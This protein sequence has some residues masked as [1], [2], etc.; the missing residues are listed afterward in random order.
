M[1]ARLLLPLAAALALG[2]SSLCAQLVRA[3]LPVQVQGT[4]AAPKLVPASYSAITDSLGFIWDVTQYGGIGRGSNCFSTAFTLSIDGNDFQPQQGMMTADGREYFITGTCDNCAV[5]RRIR[6]DPKDGHCRFIETLRNNSSE[7]LSFTVMIRTQFNSTIQSIVSDTAVSAPAQLGPKDSGVA[8]IRK[9]TPTRPQPTVLW[10]LGSTGGKLRPTLR[11]EGNTR[12]LA[13][14]PVTL[15]PGASISLIHAAAQRNLPGAA[16]APALAKLFAPLKSSKLV[17][18]L[19]P[20]ERKDFA[21]FAPV[22][23]GGEEGETAPVLAALQALLEASEITR[24]K[25]DTV[26]LDA[27]AKVSGT[28]SGGAL[29]IETEFGKADVPFADIAGI[30]GGGGVQ[31][32]VR[33]FLR[34]GEVL[35]GAVSGEKFAMTTDSG[36][37]FEID[38]AQIQ[39]LT[40]RKGGDDGKPPKSA[41]ALLTTQRGDCLALVQKA[42]ADVQMATPWGMLSVPPAEIVQLEY[43]REPFPGH[44][45]TLTDRSRLPVMLRGEEWQLATVRFG[46]VKIAP[47]SV[48]GLRGTAAKPKPPEGGDAPFASCELSGEHRL[49]GVIDLPTLHLASAKNTTPL[50]TMTITTLTR[51]VG[52]DAQGGG[53][54]VKIKLADGQE[55]SGQLVEST[56]PIRS[57]ERVW[58]V[59]AA[60][61]LSVNVPPPA[62]PK[63]ETPPTPTAPAAL[64]TPAK[65]SARTDE[66][67]NAPP[68]APPAPAPK[69]P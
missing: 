9:G 2:V 18:D 43:L 45:L 60:H 69:K 68:D 55:I 32:T 67:I 57:G 16:D 17:A 23:I 39:L 65:P 51:E 5:T 63:D 37:H 58:R 25:N 62:K 28:V 30:A 56:L 59:P 19:P 11:T 8:F 49:A 52:E 12:F 14:Y 40:L 21:N 53:A 64:K 48:R 36:L 33:I 41:A 13:S 4:S 26:L 54:L 22:G 44:R 20:K 66:I 1:N 35:A 7:T 10:M 6:V 61:I 31:R 42:A 27:A 46:N 15:A 38:L 24:E 47:Q 3:T 34:D 29:A 50:D